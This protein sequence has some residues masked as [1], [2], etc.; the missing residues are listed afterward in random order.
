MTDE[1]LIH[2]AGIKREK[3]TKKRK[4]NAKQ[5]T[6]HDKK[7][8]EKTLLLNSQTRGM[9]TSSAEYT[10]FITFEPINRKSGGKA[11]HITAFRKL[12]EE[13]TKKKKTT[14]KAAQSIN[15]STCPRGSSRGKNRVR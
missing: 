12:R 14:R 6:D 8:K 10:T 3:Q 15:E 4:R 1:T 13:E 11:T 7:K 2:S 5:M 9:H